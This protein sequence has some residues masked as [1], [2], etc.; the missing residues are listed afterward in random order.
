VRAII[1]LA[2]SL[3]L[4]VVAEGVETAEQLSFLRE[5]GCDQYQGYFCSCALIHFIQQELYLPCSA[6]I[7]G[8]ILLPA[9]QIQRKLTALFNNNNNN[10]KKK[11]PHILACND[12][13][14]IEITS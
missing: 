3:R 5:L 6:F 2:H 13:F 10:N 7:R 14:S 8:I 4:R 12:Q 1:S 11:E 9:M